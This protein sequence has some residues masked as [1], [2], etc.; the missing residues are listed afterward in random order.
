M[1]RLC[2]SR[3]VATVA[4]LLCACGIAR[5]GIAPSVSAECAFL[6]K[7]LW[8]G[9]AL[10]PGAVA[11]P[12]VTVGLGMLEVGVWANMDLDDIN[13]RS[14]EFTEVDYT[15][16]LTFGLVGLDATAGGL[17][18][19][20][21][22]KGMESTT[23]LF[24]GLSTSWIL[25]PSLTVYRDVD[26]GDGTYVSAELCPSIPVG[27]VSIDFCASVGWGDKN[28]NEFSYGVATKDLTDLGLILSSDLSLAPFLT[29]R[30]T[31]GYTRLI[32]DD[33][34]ETTDDPDNILFGVSFVT[35][36]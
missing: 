24:A 16:A 19:T 36:F 31:I 12:D 23:E 30:P 8:R 2:I 32:G 20:F 3:V 28:H 4:A 6:N 7:Y 34:R 35:G 29:V 15:A 13:E 26:Q 10:T 9:I 18:Y 33:L 5:A 17:I 14:Y 25:A 11:Q 27:S 21:T 22:E 1:N